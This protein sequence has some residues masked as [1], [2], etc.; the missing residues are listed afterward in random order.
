MASGSDYFDR[1]IASRPGLDAR[2]IVSLYTEVGLR[3]AKSDRDC[4][5]SGTPASSAE[6]SS[7][8]APAT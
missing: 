2:R 8:W 6:W 1:A 4:S 7:S 3:A 5:M